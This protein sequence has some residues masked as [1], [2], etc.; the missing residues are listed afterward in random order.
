MSYKYHNDGSVPDHIE[1]MTAGIDPHRYAGPAPAPADATKIN[2]TY[3]GENAL[4]AAAELM[5][6][7]N[8]ADTYQDK[9]ESANRDKA[10]LTPNQKPQKD[11][12]PA[13]LNKYLNVK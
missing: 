1:D 5:E 6:M 10:A 12:D 2:P 3:R 7:S 4:S 11:G 9:V 8:P 13:K